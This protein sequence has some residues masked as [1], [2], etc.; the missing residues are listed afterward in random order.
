[1]L[2]KP[3]PLAGD[4]RPANLAHRGDSDG[5]P[6]NTLAA[7]EA[8]ISAGAGGLELDVHMTRDGYIVVI[9]DD[10]VDRTTDGAGPV[11][12]MTLSRLRELDAGYRFA[13]ERGYPF[14]GRGL[15]TPTLAEVLEKFPRAFVNLEI[16]EALPGIEGTVLEVI[17]EA[18]AWD[19]VLVAAADHGI[20]VR[21][22]RLSG[23]RVLT[24]ASQREIR[25]FYLLGKLGLETL[26]RPSYDA[27]QV[28]VNYG[29]LRI[30][31]PGFLRAARGLGVRV[32]AWTINDPDEMRRLLE[33]GVDI[34]MT[35]RP[36]ELTKV[37]SE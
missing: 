28:P 25:I 35:D 8:G 26:L 17:R 2:R 23:G 36:A 27:L 22:R 12:E 6:E 4:D 31:T 1:M 16:K 7:F 11:R 21:F 29:K 32:D 5:F 37:M 19:R 13:P 14:R 18:G 9:H 10:T 20:M 33:L 30:L 15:Y 24:S 34:I 3:K